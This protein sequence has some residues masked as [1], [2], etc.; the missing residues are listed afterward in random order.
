MWGDGPAWAVWAE[1]EQW[2][3]TSKMKSFTSGLIN[4][5]NTQQSVDTQHEHNNLHKLHQNN[6]NAQVI[7]D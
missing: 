6:M 2:M 3:N 5:D 1:A 7:L 4:S